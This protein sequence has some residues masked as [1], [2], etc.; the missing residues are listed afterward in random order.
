MAYLDNRVYDNGLSVLDTEVNALVICNAEP[1]TYAEANTT[2]KVG[3]AVGGDYPG[4][5]APAA[6]VPNGRQ[7]TVNAVT[8]GAVT[9]TGTASH[10]ALIDTVNT[11][12]LA[13]GP[14]AATQGVTNGNV[15]TLPS[16][17]VRIPA[18]A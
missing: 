2:F 11:R 6:G 12:I 7:V 9:A 14:L 17:T 3:E 5:G 15:F 18:P 10:W 13:A 4:V 16:F 8:N 1:D